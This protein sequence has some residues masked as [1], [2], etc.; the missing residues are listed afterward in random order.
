MKYQ[1]IACLFDKTSETATKAYAELKDKY[2]FP[3][4]DKKPNISIDLLIT[5]GGDGMMLKA[6]HR[7]LG[8]NIPIYGMNRGS[9]GFL[10]NEYKKE[11]LMQ[12]LEH[13]VIAKL[14]PLEMF[15]RQQSGEEHTE[16]AFNE[17]SLLRETNQTA[18][19]KILVNN[20]VR[21]NYLMADGILVATPAGSSAYNFAAHGPIIPLDANV[22]AL[23]PI[24]PF[25]PRRWHGALLAR[26]SRVKFEIIE[27]DKRPVSVVADSKEIRDIEV[28]KIK[29]S[30]DKAMSILFDV[31]EGFEERVIKEQFR[32]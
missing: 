23:T 4:I 16:L 29:E 15:A 28:V 18:K 10:L 17:I 8:L 12:R 2:N 3:D 6:L 5:I 20:R 13:T 25:R 30:Q 24:S 26:N 22:L 27:G 31:D 7:F 9:L 32:I 21:L 14:C 1:K 19:I 11:R